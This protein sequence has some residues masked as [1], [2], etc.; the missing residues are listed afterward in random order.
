MFWVM[1][2]EL[3]SYIKY[4]VAENTVMLVALFTFYMNCLH[5]D[6]SCELSVIFCSLFCL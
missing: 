3:H 6:F 4:C 2:K 1:F 5:W